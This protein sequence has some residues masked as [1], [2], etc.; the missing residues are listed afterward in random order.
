[1]K[2]EYFSMA[3]M[4]MGLFNDGGDYQCMNEY[5]TEIVSVRVLCD[6][7]VWCERE[8]DLM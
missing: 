2:C 3:F 6:V 4:A 7:L 8:C 1:M 5:W